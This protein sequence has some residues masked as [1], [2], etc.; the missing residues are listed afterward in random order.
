MKTYLQPSVATVFN[1]QKEKSDL[2]E[3][4]VEALIGADIPISKLDNPK[5]RKV[6]TAKFGP[7]PSHTTIRSKIIPSIYE[8]KLS[9]LKERFSG[10]PVAL[11]LDE[12]RDSMGRNVL[13]ILCGVLNGEEYDMRL[14]DVCKF[15]FMISTINHNLFYSIHSAN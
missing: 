2:S 13:N 15:M 3:E 11:I 1:Q 14:V 8:R 9:A 5:L 7:L 10:Q 12:T 4:F 6:L